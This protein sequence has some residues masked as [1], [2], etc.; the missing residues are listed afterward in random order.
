MANVF[1]R[2]GAT[3]TNA[4]TS[5]A[6]A[7]TSLV[8]AYG[9]AATD[10][11]FVAH[12]HVQNS[13]A[14]SITLDFTN[15]T[16]ARPMPVLCVNDTANYGSS[17][18]ATPTTLS[19]GAVIQISSSGAYNILIGDGSVYFYGVEFKTFNALVNNGI[20]FSVT[21]AIPTLAIFDTCTVTIQSTGSA[22]YIQIGHTANEE[23]SVKAKWINTNLVTSSA[24]N[25]FV[26]ARLG[27]FEWCGGS[28]TGTVPTAGCFNLLS[29]GN[30][31]RVDAKVVGV[32][33]DAIGSNPLCSGEWGGNAK[34]V[35]DRLGT[36]FVATS[37]MTWSDA[38]AEITIECSDSADTNSQSQRH[39]PFGTSI[40]QTGI[41]L[42]SGGASQPDVATGTVYWS[43]KLT[44]DSTNSPQ[45]WRPFYSPWYYR[46]LDTTAASKTISL[47]CAYDNA[48]VLKDDE[49]FLEVE[50]MGDSTNN[51][52]LASFGNTLPANHPIATGSNLTDT[53]ASWTGTGGWTNKK[54]HT[55][56]KAIT[57]ASKGY[58][59]VR[60]GY[61][62]TAGADVIYTDGKV[63][64][65]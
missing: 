27:S 58:I 2:S 49:L 38:D 9:A 30:A 18:G 15:G 14:A 48:T 16:I 52:P 20:V 37:S 26:F 44:P 62:K 47:N 55:L 11:I 36:S 64:V 7:Y 5:W 8:S 34:F 54:T 1:V 39:T 46:W 61:C 33:L 45:K 32:N 23:D 35:F 42:T 40:R 57:N 25:K 51:T 17:A 21:P 6:D 3:G 12:D 4:G 53:S 59:R 50:Y 19:T 24:N 63:G 31:Y 60:V 65:A 13:G 41:Y 56:S 22:A 28:W 29:A 10:V 43:D